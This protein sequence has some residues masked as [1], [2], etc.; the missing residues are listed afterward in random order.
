MP[1]IDTVHRAKKKASGG[2]QLPEV[3][4][5]IQLLPLGWSEGHQKY[6]KI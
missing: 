6:G 4:S 5:L 1:S 2:C 3:E